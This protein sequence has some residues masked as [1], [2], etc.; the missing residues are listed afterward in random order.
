LNSTPRALEPYGGEGKALGD[1]RKSVYLLADYT[2]GYSVFDSMVE[3][4]AARWE[5]VNL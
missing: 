4:T 5:D 1:D 2:L 3:F